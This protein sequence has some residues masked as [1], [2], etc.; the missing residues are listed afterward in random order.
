MDLYDLLVKLDLIDQSS[1]SPMHPHK[2]QIARA[3][4]EAMIRSVIKAVRYKKITSEI[5]K[6]K[7][8]SEAGS[9]RILQLY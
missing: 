1:V 2:R 8:W 7:C 3:K 9:D 4:L 6:Q 5:V